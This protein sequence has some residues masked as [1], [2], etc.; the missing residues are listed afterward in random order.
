M[1]KYMMI[2][3]LFGSFFIGSACAQET[4][5]QPKYSIL[6]TSPDI[7]L[8]L[9]QPQIVAEVTVKA[10]NSNQASSVGFRKLASFIFGNNKGRDQIAMTAPV[11][12]Q[13]KINDRVQ[14][15][16]TAP[17]TT[18]Q[19]DSDQYLI[20]FTMP[21]K[22]TMETLPIPNEKDVKITQLESE[23]RIVYSFIGNRSQA[24]RDAAKK[25]LEAYILSENLKPISS[26]IIAGYDGPNVPLSQR[27]WELMYI[28]E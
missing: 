12:T 28:V 6:K 5:D 9:Y 7:E 1:L 13:K 18:S 11:T 26:F 24:I 27:R 3:S 20:R 22:W 16:M 25:K 14:I 4:I 8:R 19:T 21:S 23:K 10:N 17:V 2:F 15:A